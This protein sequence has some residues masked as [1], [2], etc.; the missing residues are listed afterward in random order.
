M[1]TRPGMALNQVKLRYTDLQLNVVNVFCSD[2][3]LCRVVRW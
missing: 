1:T 2:G 3:H